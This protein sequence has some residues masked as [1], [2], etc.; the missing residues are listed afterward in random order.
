[1]RLSRTTIVFLVVAAILL[2]VVVSLVLPE[3]RSEVGSPLPSFESTPSPERYESLQTMAEALKEKGM[4][5]GALE[6]QDMEAA[7]QPSV[8]EFATCYLMEHQELNIEMWLFE[9]KADRDKWLTSFRG[10]TMAIYGP[11][12][13]VTPNDEER[14]DAVLGALG[15]E[16]L[17]PVES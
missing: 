12:W 7:G 11:D 14:A 2:A 13:V 9:T 16:V 1:M 6:Y 5:C 15:G 8:S 4:A 10:Q 17:S 3:G